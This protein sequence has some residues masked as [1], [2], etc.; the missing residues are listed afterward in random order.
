MP[1]YTYTNPRAATVSRGWL[2]SVPRG[3]ALYSE[4][5]LSPVPLADFRQATARQ[6]E[7][8]A[9]QIKPDMNEY[10]REMVTK[11]VCRPPFPHSL[12]CA[13]DLVY[14]V[15]DVPVTFKVAR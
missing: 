9:A 1:A 3:Y 4:F 12:P 14:T 10:A 5:T 7:K 2:P 11:C 15:G 6:Y 8:L 13:G